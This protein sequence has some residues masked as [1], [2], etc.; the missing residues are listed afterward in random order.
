MKL[1]DFFSDEAYLNLFYNES[2][3][4]LIIDPGSLRII[5]ANRAAVDYYGYGEEILRMRICQINTLTE[6]QIKKAVVKV[7]TG[8]RVF[9]F[10]HRLAS[11]EIRD[12][13]VYSNLVAAKGAEYVQSAIIDITERNRAYGELY[14]SERKYRQLFKN[15]L[16]AFAYCRMTGENGEAGFE[17]LEINDA[18]GEL[19]G[20]ALEAAAGVDFIRQSPDLG[21]LA[22]DTSAVLGSLTLSGEPV[23]SVRYFSKIDK[24]LKIS[25]FCPSRGFFVM[26]ISDVTAQVLYE[27]SIQESQKFLKSIFNTLHIAIAILDE[28][29]MIVQHNDSWKRQDPSL[30]LLG[31]RCRVGM[32]YYEI[33]NEAASAYAVS[34]DMRAAGEAVRMAIDETLSSKKISSEREIIVNQRHFVVNASLFEWPETYRII[35]TFEDITERRMAEEKIKKLSLAVEQSP[36]AVIIADSEGIIEYV[37]PKFVA[38]TGYS[39]E[40]AAG[41]TM[42]IVKS[43]YH[44]KE[45]YEKLWGTIKSGAEWRGEFRNKKKSGELYWE[46]AL[47]TPIFGADGK[48][49]HFVALKEDISDR[50]AIEEE[51][52][53]SREEA[54]RARLA[55]E[56]A[57][58]AKSRFLATMSHEIRTPMNSVIGFADMLASTSLND[59]QK[60]LLEY[61]KTSS[62]ALL[63]LINDVLD[64]SKIEAGRLEVESV[65]FELGAILDQVVSIT[66][67][68]ASKK[69]I[70]F[71]YMLDPSIDFKVFSD[72]ARL[73]QVLLNLVDNAIKFTP[74]SRCVKI[75][76]TLENDGPGSAVIRFT[77]ED[78]GIGIP[79]D[80]IPTLFQSFSQSDKTIFRRFGGTGLGLTISN[81][82]VRILGGGGI[83]LKSEE[84]SG[85]VF[86]FELE[87]KK[88]AKVGFGMPEKPPAGAVDEAAA[89]EKYSILLVEDN[90]SN[91][92]L[93]TKVL[94]KFGHR[95]AVAENGEEA[96]RMSAEK[97][98]DLILMDIQM[99]VMDGLEATRAIRARGDRVPIIAMTAS[100]MKGDYDTCM[101]ADMDGYI[102]KPISVAEL[103]D[104]IGGVISKAREAGRGGPPSNDFSRGAAGPD[105]SRAVNAISP[106]ADEAE[107]QIKVFDQDRLMYNMG[108]IKELAV[109]SVNMFLEY[110]GQYYNETGASLEEKNPDRIRRSAHKFKGTSLNACAMRVA[111]LLL[112]IET[113]AKNGSI[114]ECS[115]LFRR[116]GEQ[117]EV[118]KA[119]P[120]VRDFLTEK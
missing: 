21:E 112:K 70:K 117:I 19:F 76:I 79:A 41:S 34:K 51:L 40:D 115:E 53:A 73:R 8:S 64:L 65:E 43:G 27:Q 24:W 26:M 97:R 32:N 2:V 81:H 82:L 58:E 108:G 13:E 63:S 38:L 45:F 87:M 74:A 71:S 85:S 5:D 77:V 33:C 7:R 35:I 62:G 22:E 99:P 9:H 118:F 10:R 69:S 100:A 15:M 101:A 59:E 17:I 104:T 46:S 11:G 30:L 109:D 84:G 66:R 25:Y 120:G 94:V 42:R 67:V 95:V 56:E 14:E 119:D 29:G 75:A 47:I 93:A 61:V 50:K 78:K 105:Q 49:S 80:R 23:R 44:E 6:E 116:L 28:N 55:A 107:S 92:T 102:P 89:D 98:Y 48:I 3:P 18:F 54:V 90:P 86:Y 12:V 106:G 91:V 39:F 111:D 31:P 20:V 96:V 36:A 114:E 103:N 68:N 110:C 72:P 16:E 4:K 88:G 113:G 1:S 37:N 60:E 52:R 83:K 57:N